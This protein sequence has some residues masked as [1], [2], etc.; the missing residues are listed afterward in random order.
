MQSNSSLVSEAQLQIL[1]EEQQQLAARV[2][3]LEG[4]H[5]GDLAQV[6]VWTL[7]IQYVGD[8]ACVAI[9]V[10]CGAT[11]ITTWTGVFE[12]GMP[13]VPRY[14]CFREGPPL[15]EA[16]QAY[17]EES[18]R[19]PDVLV[20]DGHGIAHP[21]HFGV[22]CWLGVKSGWPCIGLA[23]RSLLAYEDNLG[24]ARHSVQAIYWGG[25]HCGYAW[26]SQAQV[27]PVYLS[28]GHAVSLADALE[29]VQYLGGDYRVIEPMRRADQAA[30]QRALQE[31]VFMD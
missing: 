31:D 22:A 7:D 27:K 29:L 20:I 30:R 26:R 11:P 23:K 17:K 13:Y 3:V 12:A 25:V 21:R 24:A 9:D 6:E 19:T 1:A 16:L 18:G 15:W 14:F 8:R 5:L 10:Q 4:H 28:V 2:E